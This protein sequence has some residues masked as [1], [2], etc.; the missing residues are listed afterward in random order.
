MTKKTSCET[1]KKN[2]SDEWEGTFTTTSAKGISKEPAFYDSSNFNTFTRLLCKI[3]GQSI[4][5]KSQNNE[6]IHWSEQTPAHHQQ[7]N[8]NIVVVCY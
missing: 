2:C 7:K 6:P 5:Q 3:N 8:N 1:K 4:G